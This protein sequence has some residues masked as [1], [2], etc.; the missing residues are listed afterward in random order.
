M[1]S[2]DQ[3]LTYGLVGLVV[4]AFIGFLLR[5]DAFLIGQLPFTTVITRGSSLTGMDLILVPTA[6]MSFNVLLAGAIVGGLIGG[7]VGGF[8]PRRPKGLQKRLTRQSG[9]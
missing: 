1:T 7:V 9:W 4:G 2:R 3:R 6:Q 5:P 8:R